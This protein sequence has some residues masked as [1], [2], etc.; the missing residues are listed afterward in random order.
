LLN[1][2]LVKFPILLGVWVS[3]AHAV[4]SWGMDKALGADHLRAQ[5]SLLVA[6]ATGTISACGGGILAD[7]FGL[8]RV[9]WEFRRPPCLEGPSQPI[10]KAFLCALLYY[11]LRDPHQIL[12][13]PGLALNPPEARALIGIA[14]F[15][16]N[17]A[18]YFFP[19][20]K[21]T[22]VSDSNLIYG[23]YAYLS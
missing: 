17:V 19:S 3:S 22:E 12:W 4:T 18:L 11:S 9:V 10:E 2:D 5:Q 15:E 20:F 14:M 16:L 1:F 21:L 13:L 7:M 6:L 8:Q 23:I